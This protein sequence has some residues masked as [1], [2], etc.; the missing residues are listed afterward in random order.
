MQRQ[1]KGFILEWTNETMT[2][3]YGN[4]NKTHINYKSYT[5]GLRYENLKNKNNEK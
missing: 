5:M 3:I 4:E 2:Y 1:K